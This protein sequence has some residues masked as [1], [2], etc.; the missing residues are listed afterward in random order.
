ML[1]RNHFVILL[2]IIAGRTKMRKDPKSSQGHVLSSG[3]QEAKPA[4]H[5]S[6][7][8]EMRQV[9]LRQQELANDRAKEAAKRRKQKET[10]ER[11][12]RN[13]IAKK[14]PPTNGNRLGDGRSNSKNNGGNSSGRNPLQPWAS[15]TASYRYNSIYLCIF[16]LTNIPVSY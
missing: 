9:R 14:K 7:Q 2:N 10:E 4:T 1:I 6:H 8:E 16:K 3:G 5:S 13:H 15:S 12:R 11:E